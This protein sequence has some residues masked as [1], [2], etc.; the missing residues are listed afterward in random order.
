MAN[1]MALNLRGPVR[2]LL[3]GG[4]PRGERDR[5]DA[6][7]TTSLTNDAGPLAKSSKAVTP[8]AG[9]SARA[10]RGPG[11]ARGGTSDR[12]P[13]PPRQR[14]PALAALAILL[15]VGGAALAGVLALR[16]DDRQPVLV[17]A[18][19]ITAGQQITRQD[20]AVVRVSGDG[21][22]LLPASLAPQVVGLYAVQPIRGGRLLDNGLIA[23]TGLMKPGRSAVGVVMK[24]GSVPL[25]LQVGDDVEVIN[26]QEGVATVISAR[27]TI[28]GLSEKAKSSGFSTSSSTAVATIVVDADDA[29]K[30][31]AASVAGTVALIKLESAKK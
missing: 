17:A 2:R 9:V 8:D 5:W 4:V 31:A 1:D 16:Y 11:R 20:L 23:R 12:L 13:S 3:T 15:I 29:A 14:K 30:V 21:L 25:N 7:L 27:A 26:A 28:G 10:T 18:H 6:G 22:R 24:T 19:D